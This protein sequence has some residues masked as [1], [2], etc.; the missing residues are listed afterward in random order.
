[1]QK[2]DIDTLIRQASMGRQNINAMNASSA[3]V[4][5]APIVKLVD[6]IID[7][8]IDMRA[9]DIHIEPQTSFMR[10]RFRVDGELM[11]FRD[12]IPLNIKEMM[13]ARIKIMAKLDTTERRKP[14]DGRITF[15]HDET[16]VDIRVSTMPTIDGES[17]VLRLLN[18]SR[19]LLKLDE[20]DFSETNEKIFKAWCHKPYGLILNV[21]PVN[22]GKTTTLYAALSELNTPD[23]NI[24][25]IEDPVEYY[26][27]GV[28]QIQVNPKVDLTFAN[29]L[30]AVLRQDP[31]VCMVGEIRDEETAEIAIRAA[32]IG[33]LIFTTLHTGNAVG[34]IFRLLDMGIKPYLLS[35]ALLGVMAQR[36]VRRLCPY[37]KEQYEISSNTADALF[38]GRRFE[39]GMMAYRAVGCDK[40]NHTGY[41]GRMAIHEM[42]E[43]SDD[44]R[45]AITYEHEYVKISDIAKKTNMVPL[46]DDGIEKIKCGKTSIAEVRRVLYGGY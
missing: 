27:T 7:E 26:L 22:S 5:S 8:A 45:N 1:M 36:L 28:N 17:I 43:I 16:D 39:H 32:M 46:I 12:E 40:C 11:S 13:T 33:R 44:L 29:G 24:V 2:P 35:A 31:D 15:R 10:V 21:G 41:I 3:A 23:K 20:L 14:Q 34:S 38:M 25:T 18:G 30:R 4:Q 42:L 9:S 6:G 19:N 37:C